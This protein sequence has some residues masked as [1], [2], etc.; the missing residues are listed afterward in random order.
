M[1]FSKHRITFAHGTCGSLSRNIFL[2]SWPGE[3][4]HG[5]PAHSLSSSVR[6]SL[7]LQERS[8]VCQV[9]HSLFEGHWVAYHFLCATVILS[10]IFVYTTQ[11]M[12]FLR[13]RLCFIH[14]QYLEYCLANSTYSLMNELMNSIFQVA[15][16]K[17]CQKSTS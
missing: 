10:Y 12:R 16:Q 5:S 2:S 1:M 15:A 4:T 17:S 11:I 8:L 9:S 13:E 3:L 14:P 6:L 7:L